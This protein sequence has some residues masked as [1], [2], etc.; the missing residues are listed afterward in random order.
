ML[1]VQYE[2]WVGIVETTQHIKLAYKRTM[3]AIIVA[4]A[5]IIIIVVNEIMY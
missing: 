5:V 3:L 1:E 2:L 4:A